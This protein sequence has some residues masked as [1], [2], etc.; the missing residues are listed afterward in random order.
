VGNSSDK[1]SAGNESADCDMADLAGRHVFGSTS[2]GT[3]TVTA[4]HALLL[5][6][7]SFFLEAQPQQGASRGKAPLQESP[8]AHFLGLHWAGV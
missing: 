8:A 5:R 3:A 1:I 6:Q 2:R 4:R 7:K